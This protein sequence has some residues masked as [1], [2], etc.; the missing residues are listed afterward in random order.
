MYLDYVRSC[1][2]TSVA[3]VES[4]YF[5][6]MSLA[7]LYSLNHSIAYRHMFVFVRQQATILRNAIIGNK[8]VGHVQILLFL[9]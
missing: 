2:F 8:E 5:M 1:Q 4:I 3:S 6:R 7:E 9:G